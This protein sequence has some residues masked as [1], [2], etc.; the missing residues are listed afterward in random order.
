MERNLHELHPEKF[1]E[2][3][4]K[5]DSLSSTLKAKD[6]IIDQLLNEITMVKNEKDDLQNEVLFKK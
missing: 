1:K 2:L 5:L 4:G 3:N 6:N